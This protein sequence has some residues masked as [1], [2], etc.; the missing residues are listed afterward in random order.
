MDR[1]AIRSSHP[2]EGASH[3]EVLA[4]KVHEW[5]GVTP[6]A[7]GKFRCEELLGVPTHASEQQ[8]LEA[9]DDRLAALAKHLHG[10]DHDLAERAMHMVQTAGDKLLALAKNTPVSAEQLEAHDALANVLPDS[11]NRRTRPR[12]RVLTILAKKWP[13][14]I[15]AGVV[16]AAAALFGLA[17]KEAGDPAASASV[18][19][20]L[21][22]DAP[23]L[24]P[25]PVS[26]E[27]AP[28]AP[29][30]P[31]AV[32]PA[33]PPPVP[34]PEKTAPPPA[35][36]A[37][38]PEE[39]PAPPV[40]TPDKEPQEE[41]AVQ[42]PAVPARSPAPS[43]DEV[44][45]YADLEQKSPT[46]AQ[47]TADQLIEEARQSPDKT[48]Q[49][50]WLRVALAKACAAND[51]D[52]A[53]RVLAERQ[54]LFDEDAAVL[55]AKA[56]AVLEVAGNPK[57]DAGAV[58]THVYRL[59]DQLCDDDP[60]LART[61][62][63]QLQRTP[64][65]NK[66]QVASILLYVQK[67]GT[68]SRRIGLDEQRAALEQDPE[69][70]KANRVVGEYE[71][72]ERGNWS[73][74]HQLQKSGDAALAA[75]AD[76]VAN[77]NELSAQ[78]LLQLAKDLA[79]RKP[80]RPGAQGM[81]VECCDLGK[82]KTN[83]PA[84]VARLNDLKLEIVRGHGAILPLVQH[85]QTADGAPPPVIDTAAPLPAS[86]PLLAGSPA[87][88]GK[89]MVTVR[90]RCVVAEQNG[91]LTL[92]SVS[93]HHTWISFAHIP[94]S[95]DAL[96]LVQSGK[97]YVFTA[98]FSRTADG[99]TDLG[100]KQGGSAFLVPLPNGRHISVVLDNNTHQQWHEKGRYRSGISPDVPYFFLPD[101]KPNPSHFDH[102][103]PLVQ[104]DGR[105][106]TCRVAVTM[107]GNRIAVEGTLIEKGKGTVVATFS[108]VGPATVDSAS[109][110]LKEGNGKPPA[111][112]VF[113]FGGGGGTLHVR[114]AALAPVPK[115]P[116]RRK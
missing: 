46:L 54:K 66:P 112:P 24:S 113:G 2:D 103:L 44:E 55:R 97:P 41:P 110:F 114:N 25:P 10:P 79:G 60:A 58:M 83:D 36:K 16:G 99:R 1:M 19:R 5:L 80:S 85:T 86:V 40:K 12:T 37:A 39:A 38:E 89:R 102:Q 3:R 18:E 69:D 92:T 63:N 61:L 77:R 91:A 115:A 53:M 42:S 4:Q 105:E 116:P 93:G 72:L 74:A 11:L 107:Q 48:V 98:T 108:F 27:T 101:A 20:A 32:V 14:T 52:A 15:G 6:D 95:P 9:V 57:A 47:K 70:P 90:D 30:E 56:Q 23:E 64:S 7:R 94:L 35:P 8:I 75:L 78:E 50:V 96:A 71:C 73:H 76:R 67:L 13:L 100:Q 87:E 28:A 68:T 17:K 65:V 31:V 88:M 51:L 22:S 104:E 43:K 33:V 84:L 49:W 106:Y 81:A 29:A 21:P 62:L 59:I 26:T 109:Y 82:T 45:Q 34:A 111:V